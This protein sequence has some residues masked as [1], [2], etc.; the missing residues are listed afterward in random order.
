MVLVLLL[1]SWSLIVAVERGRLAPLLASAAFVGVGFNTKMLVALGI[2]PAFGLVYVLGVASPW[3]A[4][5]SR[6]AAAFAVLAAVSV[7]WGL[8]VDLTP[9]E[10]RPFVGGSR[11]NSVS[12]LVLGYNGLERVLDL[13]PTTG[14]SPVAGYIPGP[15]RA[16]MPG[17]GG[18]PG[19]L[20]LA[21]QE[22]AGQI[23]WLIPIAA[24]GAVAAAALEILRRPLAPRHLSILLWAVW[25]GSYAVVFSFSRGIIHPYYLSVIAPPAAALF[26]VGASALREASGRGRG[27][28]RGTA[29]RLDPDGRL[30]SPHPGPSSALARSPAAV[31]GGRC[32]RLRGGPAGIAPPGP[33]MGG[34]GVPPAGLARGR[35]ALR[36]AGPGGLVAH[37]RHGPGESHDPRRGPFALDRDRRPRAAPDGP[38]RGPAVG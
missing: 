9:A 17:F 8:V 26:G 28:D 2:L 22:L 16:G 36:A 7:S 37:A 14:A 34:V 1:A 32:V 11:D 27:G 25:L 24:I 31:P 21:N 10:N 13:G 5:L 4:R 12:G 3:R 30:A 20:R 35:M 19:P 18:R 33:A 15:D 29:R 38:H 23:T 6:L